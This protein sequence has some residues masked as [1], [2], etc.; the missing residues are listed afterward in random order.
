MLKRSGWMVLTAIL[1]LP[2]FIVVGTAGGSSEQSAKQATYDT[3]R[4]ATDG[5]TEVGLAQHDG[6]DLHLPPVRENIELVGKLEMN[7]PEAFRWDPEPNPD[8]PDPTQPQLVQGQIADVAVYKNSAYLSRGPSRRCK[9]GGF[10]S[11][12]ISNPPSR[13]SSAF[14]PALPDT[15][16][17]EGAHAITLNTPPSRATCWRSTTSPAAPN[18]VGGFDLY[19]VTNPA[20]PEIARR[21]AWAT[22]RRDREASRLAT[23]QDPTVVPNSAHTIFMWQDGAKAYAVIVDN[24]ELHDVDIFDITNPREPGLIAEFDLVALADEQGIDIVDNGAT[25]TRSSTTTW[26]SRRSAACRRCSSSYWD[27]GYVK[28]D[29]N[30]PANADV[31]SA[32]RTSARGPADRRSAT[33]G[34]RAAGGQRPPGRVLLRQQ[35][36][37]GGGRGLQPLPRRIVRDHHRAERRASTSRRR[38]AAARQQSSCPTARSTARSSTAATAADASTTPS[39]RRHDDPARTLARGRGGDPRARSAG[40]LDGLRRRRDLNDPTTLLPGREGRERDRRRARTPSC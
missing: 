9:R 39:R 29:V 10:F 12:D 30:D 14:V 40:R 4:S 20:E 28:L 2:L 34:L 16:H 3:S 19:D 37:A 32:T 25:A 8:V 36:R 38:S 18:G 17:G 21:R 5:A 31:S 24:I 7:T 33:G 35:V 26:S 23:E 15:Y 1:A 27:A 6:T 13:S 22:S 11:V